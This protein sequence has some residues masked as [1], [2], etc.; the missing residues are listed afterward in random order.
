MYAGEGEIRWKFKKWLLLG[1]A[2]VEG[3]T[4]ALGLK[5]FEDILFFWVGFILSHITQFFLIVVLRASQAPIWWGSNPSWVTAV[6][7]YLIIFRSEQ[8]WGPTSHAH[9]SK[10]WQSFSI[11][12]FLKQQRTVLNSCQCGQYGPSEFTKNPLYAESMPEALSQVNWK[13]KLLPRTT[14]R[15]CTLPSLAFALHFHTQFLSKEFLSWIIA[16][17]IFLI[18]LSLLNLGGSFWGPT[19]WYS[20]PTPGSIL[21]CHSHH[22]QRTISAWNQTVFIMYKATSLILALSLNS[23]ISKIDLYS[24]RPGYLAVWRN[25]FSCLGEGGK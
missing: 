8:L 15:V 5:L 6:M 12:P 7:K 13:E 23:A 2:G 21:W 9:T 3:T 10:P 25:S 14:P 22:T 17:P 4:E 1:R 11:F 24:P 20:G 18:T 16:T 19:Q